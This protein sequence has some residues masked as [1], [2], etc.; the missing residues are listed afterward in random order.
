[1]PQLCSTCVFS[2]LGAATIST[3]P[4]ITMPPMGCSGSK[5]K[6]K[7][8]EEEVLVGVGAGEPQGKAADTTLSPPGEDAAPLRACLESRHCISPTYPEYVVY[9]QENDSMSV[10]LSRSVLRACVRVWPW[11]SGTPK[12]SKVR[13]GS[14][15]TETP[16]KSARVASDTETSG[17]GPVT[18]VHDGHSQ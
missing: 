16:I 3:P 6:K 13:A 12:P 9:V 8:K 1:M 18:S 14:M 17:T 5:Q 11:F 4:G 15:S 2:C 10:P 7:K